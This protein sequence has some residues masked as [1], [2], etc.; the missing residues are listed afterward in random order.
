MK[1]ERSNKCQPVFVF[2]Y[3]I[4]HLTKYTWCSFASQYLSYTQ[5]KILDVTNNVRT[6]SCVVIRPTVFLIREEPVKVLVNLK[7]F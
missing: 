7:M 6:P 2:V 4:G 3:F 1:Q 5:W